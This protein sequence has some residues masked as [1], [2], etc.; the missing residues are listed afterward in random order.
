M[1]FFRGVAGKLNRLY[2]SRYMQPIS[3]LSNGDILSAL[4]HVPC[5]ILTPTL[6]ALSNM[7]N[8]YPAE[9]L[10]Y[11]REKKIHKSWEW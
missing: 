8:P 1:R 2:G 3:E 7:R 11:E 5:R 4:S 6:E 9:R 10:W